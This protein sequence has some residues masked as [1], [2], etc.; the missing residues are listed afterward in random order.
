MKESTLNR[1][2]SAERAL[3]E[4]KFGPDDALVV[5]RTSAK[6]EGSFSIKG[7]GAGITNLILSAICDDEDFKNIVVNAL[8]MSRMMEN[9]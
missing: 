3:L 6:A 1:F 7:N 5:L 4:E 9:K 2:I 8:K